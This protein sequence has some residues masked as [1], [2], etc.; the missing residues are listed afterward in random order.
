MRNNER[1]ALIIVCCA[2]LIAVAGTF[3]LP[4]L[5]QGISDASMQRLTDEYGEIAG[6]GETLTLN[7]DEESPKIEGPFPGQTTVLETPFFFSG[8]LDVAVDSATVY[9]SPLQAGIL[10][11]D[12]YLYNGKLFTDSSFKDEN[13][14]FLLCSYTIHNV[15]AVLSE[16]APTSTG[17]AGF[18]LS[19]IIE[20]TAI[21]EAVYFNDGTFDFIDPSERGYFSLSQGKTKTITV[22]YA[23]HN[24]IPSDNAFEFRCGLNKS[25][26]YRFIVTA[27]DMRE[28]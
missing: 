16:K 2:L 7:A 18:L 15:N 22:G 20:P 12:Q 14:K 27:T 11:S 23:I 21:V 28:G 3:G 24:D 9:D 8:S 1:T 10:D 25:M 13:F 26:R 6:S 19:G 4:I 5:L 17:K